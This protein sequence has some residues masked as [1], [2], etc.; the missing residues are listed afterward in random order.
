MSPFSLGGAGREEG[1]RPRHTLTVV[2]DWRFRHSWRV[3]PAQSPTARP[4]V[5]D[6]PSRGRWMVGRLR[7]TL[8][9]VPTVI[10]RALRER[11]RVVEFD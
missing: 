7:H 10:K 6:I 3:P 11:G 2:I 1:G 9:I 8:K 5:K 4:A